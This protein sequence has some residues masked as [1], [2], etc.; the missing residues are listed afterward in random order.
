[1]D[2]WKF[3]LLMAASTTGG[4]ATVAVKALLLVMASWLSERLSILLKFGHTALLVI[5]LTTHRAT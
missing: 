1:M 5:T 4:P 3:R 2:I